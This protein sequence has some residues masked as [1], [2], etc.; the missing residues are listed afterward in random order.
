[1]SSLQWNSMRTWVTLAGFASALFLPPWAPLIAVV[2][3]SLRYRAWEAIILGL[4]I[5]MLWL[6]IGGTDAHVVPLFTILSIVIA[7]GLEPLRV[8]LMR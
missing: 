3:L 7:W 8:E 5:D 6:P 2:L 4:F 1:M